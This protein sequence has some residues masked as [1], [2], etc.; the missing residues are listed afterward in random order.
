MV[1]LGPTLRSTRKTSRLVTFWAQR[2][3]ETGATLFDEGKV[4][5]RGEGDGLEMVDMVSGLLVGSC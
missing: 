3:V 4:E 5:A 1:S 2:W